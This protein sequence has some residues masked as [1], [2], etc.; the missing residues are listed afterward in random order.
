MDIL[1]PRMCPKCGGRLTVRI[2]RHTR[3]TECL[4]CDR[5]TREPIRAIIRR[6][7]GNL[8]LAC[9]MLAVFW[10]L[11]CVWGAFRPL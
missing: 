10:L 1:N 5:R 7:V 4:H 9:L 8:G 6:Q 2:T 11:F 3:Y